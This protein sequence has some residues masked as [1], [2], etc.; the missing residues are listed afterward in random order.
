MDNTLNLDEFE[1]LSGV[2]FTRYVLKMKDIRVDDN[3][4]TYFAQR[5]GQWDDVHLETAI[6]WLG[7]SGSLPAH[8]AIADYIDHRNKSIR[9]LAV[10]FTAEMK[11]EV[12]ARIMSRVIE[13]LERNPEAADKKALDSVLNKPASKEARTLVEQYLRQ[14]CDV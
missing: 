13:A 12:N 10:G 3:F 7:K 14:H 1:R 11:P 9:F 6:W 4:L 5:K 2:D 8:Q